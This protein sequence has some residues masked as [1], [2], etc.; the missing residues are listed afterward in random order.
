MVDGEGVR[1]TLA[2]YCQLCD[3]GRFDEWATLYTDDA[4]F[5]VMDQVHEG[6]DAIKAFIEE[7]Q[8][9]EKRGKH[10]MGQSVIEEHGDGRTVSVVSDYTFIARN[11][12]GGYAI[13]SAGRYHDELVQGDDGSWRFRSREIRFLGD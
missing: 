7:A 13:T 2:L 8:S 1:R 10:F 11:Q 12:K 3:D 9:P 5:L 6:P 4:R